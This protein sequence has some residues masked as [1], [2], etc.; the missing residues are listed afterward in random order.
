MIPLA[1]HE[2]L[3]EHLDTLYPQTDPAPS[4]TDRQI[5]Y[6]A[7]QRSVVNYLLRQIEEQQN[8]GIQDDVLIDT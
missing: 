2:K 5:M 1:P 6:E 7:G 3:I 4:M 8:E